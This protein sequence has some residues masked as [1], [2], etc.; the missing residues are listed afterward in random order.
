MA[1][2]VCIE[3]GCPMLTDRTRCA[4]HQSARRKARGTDASNGY[5]REFKRLRR[6]WDARLAAGER[7]DCW[8][9]GLPIDPAN[10]HLGHDDNDRSIIRGPEHPLCNLRAAGYATARRSAAFDDYQPT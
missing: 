2:R 5:G 1:K 10:W 7:V 9:C 6:E 3:P 8:R 4:Q